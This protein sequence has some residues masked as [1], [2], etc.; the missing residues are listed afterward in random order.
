MR[1]ENGLIGAALFAGVSES[2][3]NLIVGWTDVAKRL[4]SAAPAAGVL[5]AG[6]AESLGFT[7]AGAPTAG[8]LV[9]GVAEAGAV[10]AVVYLVGNTVYKMGKYM[11]DHSCVGR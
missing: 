7:A 9:S 8:S 10:G 5:T 2:Y 11:S 4:P 3:K 6:A 1:C